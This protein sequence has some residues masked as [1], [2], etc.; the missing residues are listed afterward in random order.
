MGA[1]D[2][3]DDEARHVGIAFAVTCGAGAATAL[4]AAVVFVPSLV[5]YAKRKTL[6]GGLGLAAGVMVYVSLVEIAVK[7]QIAFQDSGMSHEQ[8]YM[9][10]TLSFFGGVLLMQVS[11]ISFC[12]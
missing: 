5:Q 6:A 9:Y 10:A 11:Y 4:G 3:S 7:S 1:T 8:A 12:G 2:D